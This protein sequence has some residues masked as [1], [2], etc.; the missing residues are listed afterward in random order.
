[1]AEKELSFAKNATYNT[2]GTL[3]NGFCLWLTTLVVVR[4]SDDYANAGVWQLAI[5][6]TNIFA[7]IAVFNLLT[8]Y[9]S[10]V[11]EKYKT[12]EY[13]A[14][15][16]ITCVF[17]IALCVIYSLVCGYRSGQLLCIIA[18]MFCRAIESFEGI[19]FGIDQRFCRMDYVG[20][21][22]SMRGIFDIIVFTVILYFTQ[23]LTLSAVGMIATTALI[24]IF[25]DIPKSKQFVELKIDFNKG[26]ILNLL[27][28]SALSVVSIA[29]ITAINTIPRQFLENIYDENNL[30]Y[31]ATIAA[32][33]VV[34]QVV[35]VGIF[36][37]ILKDLAI[38]Y[39]END[40][41]KLKSYALKIFLM[42]VTFA[43][44]GLIGAKLFG[45]FLYTL[46]YGESI[47]P[48]CYL[49]YALV[50]CT[51]MYAACWA[52]FSMLVV[53]RKPFVMTIFS[54]LSVLSTVTFSSPLINKFF[55]N[56]TSYSILIAYAMFFVLG[57]AY[58]L[59]N[60]GNKKK[61]I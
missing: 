17:A 48:Y 18:Y 27:K 12:G 1:M 8:F 21:S 45:T 59:I 56:G 28:E 25:Y 14:T 53:M 32:P 35:A 54:I 24:L 40:V 2:I 3:I 15:Q 20:I 61:D 39:D 4:L 57:M 37:P 13:L 9:V 43:I 19:L 5:S 49:M 22:Y 23:N 30:G 55:L 41:K 16:F 47:R 26:D 52:V 36:N 50:G 31:F 11:K 46:I 58:I 29:A 10:D 51:V 42:L 38:A 33:L 34:I 44:I 60:L 6:V 7:T